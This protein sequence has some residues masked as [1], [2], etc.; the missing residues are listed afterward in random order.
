M[1]SSYTPLTYGALNFIFLSE[2]CH[3]FYNNVQRIQL[4]FSCTAS[5]ELNLLQKVLSGTTLCSLMHVIVEE[6]KGD[7]NST[8]EKS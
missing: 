7:D 5:W 3:F 4:P 8:G 1:F 2:L 6:H